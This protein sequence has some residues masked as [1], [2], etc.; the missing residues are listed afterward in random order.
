MTIEY[1]RPVIALLAARGSA[2]DISMPDIKYKALLPIRSRPMADYVLQALQTSSVER[3]FIVQPEDEELEK[4]LTPHPKNHFVTCPTERPHITDSLISGTEAMLEYFGKEG[5][6][7]RVIMSVPCDIPLV[8]ADDF[9]RLL[10]RI[11]GIDADVLFTTIKL[12]EIV[13]A[14]PERR[15]HSLF[16]KDL[17]AAYAPQN[18]CFM[19]GNKFSFSHDSDGKRYLAIHD[20]SGENMKNLAD[21]V[22]ELRKRR[23]GKMFWFLMAYKVLLDRLIKKRHFF[24]VARTIQN[25]L[26]DNLTRDNLQEAFMAAF[27][28]KLKIMESDSAAFSGDIDCLQ[29]LNKILDTKSY[30][31]TD[32]G[33]LDA[34]GSI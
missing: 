25:F 8:R 19:D 31:L 5:L 21:M 24:T 7:R 13:T 20:R 11:Q 14:F 33:E 29:D 23:H 3:I 2:D 18:L 28:L 26:T 6:S 32:N 30:P 10:Y 34:I 12:D 16:L 9:E 17:D 4:F 27:N 22:E 1:P 15:Y